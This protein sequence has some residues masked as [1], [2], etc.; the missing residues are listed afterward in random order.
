VDPGWGWGQIATFHLHHHHHHH[1]HRHHHHHHHHH[2]HLHHREVFSRQTQ[3]DP[4]F[5]EMK[6]LEDKEETQTTQDQLTES[7]Q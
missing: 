6:I 3:Y 2:H 4:V 1:H 7:S 5:A